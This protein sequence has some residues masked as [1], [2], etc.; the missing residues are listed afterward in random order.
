MFRYK[1]KILILILLFGLILLYPSKA[2]AEAKPV[3]TI[4]P[5]LQEVRFNS[6]DPTK[7][8]NIDITNNSKSTQSLKLSALDFGS[9]NDSGGL[10]FAGSNSSN[11]TS[12]YGLA[13]WLRL[14]TDIV[15]IEPGQKANIVATII[16]D[17]SLRPGG[18]YAAIVATLVNED[19]AQANQVTINQKI[20]SL[21]LANKVGGEKYDLSLINIDTNTAKLHLPSTIVLDFKNTGNVHIVPR[22]IVKIVTSSGK[23]IARGVINQESS[24]VLPEMSRQISVEMH[25]VNS[26]NIWPT[27]YHI[28]VDY[29]YEGIDE[30]ARKDKPL[31][32]ANLPS[33]V[34]ISAIIS[35]FVWYCIKLRPKIK[36]IYN[37]L[38][39]AVE[40]LRT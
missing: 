13:N 38:K 27:V 8:F 31:Y 25:K 32:Y 16:N 36:V 5:F 7:E 39:T 11:L 15:T 18:H 37:Q 22:G 30:F 4:S 10:V 9:L 29:R 21:V 28:Q 34:I 6:T 40:K 1:Y 33:L 23:I 35:L 20:S 19:T 2:A 26:A 3:I 17:L 24:F 12:K 14:N